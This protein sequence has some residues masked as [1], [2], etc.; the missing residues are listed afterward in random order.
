[1]A[2]PESRGGRSMPHPTGDVDSD[3]FP[4]RVVEACRR[5]ARS[6]TPRLGRSDFDDIGQGTAVELLR[7]RAA[8]EHLSLKELGAYAWRVAASLVAQSARAAR[9]RRSR[10]EGWAGG[11]SLVERSPEERLMAWEAK[12]LV[13]Q[14]VARLPEALRQ[15]TVLCDLE[16][17]SQVV[18]SHLLGMSVGTVKRRHAEA[19]SA[20]QRA[21]R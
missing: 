21:C 7:R 20:L 10:E 3:G 19:R 17:V 4:G 16:G 12:A 1:M 6:L 9:R 5:V 18:A 11:Q 8:L 13:T 14:E 2:N 15:V